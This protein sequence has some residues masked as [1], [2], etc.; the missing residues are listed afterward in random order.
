MPQRICVLVSK[1]VL[2]DYTI[3][4]ILADKDI[5]E[6][7][8]IFFD[9]ET[10]Q[11]FNSSKITHKVL[12]SKLINYSKGLVLPFCQ[13]SRDL[14][15]FNSWLIP[16]LL[17]MMSLFGKNFSHKIL[18]YQKILSVRR[19]RLSKNFD[20]VW[21]SWSKITRAENNLLNM[22]SRNGIRCHFIPD[23]LIAEKYTMGQTQDAVILEHKPFFVLHHKDLA[24]NAVINKEI[25]KALL[26]TKEVRAP[27]TIKPQI[28]KKH[29]NILFLA[30][31]TVGEDWEAIS[32]DSQML[33]IDKIFE[34]IK[35]LELH[36][37][38]RFYYRQRPLKEHDENIKKL[39]ET[40]DNLELNFINGNKHSLFDYIF[41][42]D[43]I[44]S[45]FTSAF[46][47]SRGM[48][49]RFMYMDKCFQEIT[50]RFPIVKSQFRED[51]RCRAIVDESVIL[52]KLNYELK[53]YKSNIFLSGS[54]R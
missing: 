19:F 2:L 39:E 34:V 10:F 36:Q 42:A 17:W 6:V 54:D 49:M 5:R 8:F 48:P 35:K 14:K 15:Y 38:V 21:I 33:R 16:F 1:P 9:F 41:G 50:K 43:F 4:R 44:I 22:L 11:T 46:V 53:A 37:N 27:E 40:Y 24:K 47:Y 3:W 7:D 18:S 13:Q 20:E 52:D 32:L 31:K 25:P 12:A 30:Q 23:A 45:E 29:F 26:I 51:L 28:N